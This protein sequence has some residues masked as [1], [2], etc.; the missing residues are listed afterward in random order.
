M[1]A[2]RRRFDQ[3]GSGRGVEFVS[4]LTISLRSSPACASFDFILYRGGNSINDGG[5]NPYLLEDL[6]V[7][8]HG[9]VWI[10]LLHGRNPRTGAEVV[11]ASLARGGFMV[12]D[13]REER[14]IQVRPPPAWH[15]ARAGTE[16]WAIG[17]APD[18]AIYV[19]TSYSRGGAD[20]LLRWNW[21][22]TTLEVVVDLP[23]PNFLSLD[24]APDGR[25]YLSEYSKNVLY[26]FTPATGA[27][28]DLGGFPGIE[29]HVSNVCCA[30]DGWVYVAVTDYK[31]TRCLAISPSDGKHFAIESVNSAPL[32]DGAGHVL[33]SRSQ[34]GGSVWSEL[35]GGRTVPIDGARVQLTKTEFCKGP[36][37]KT[38]NITPLAFADGGYIRRIDG[39]KFTH[40]DSKGAARSFTVERED[41]P[42][43]IFSVA[44]GGGKIWGGTFIPLTLFSYDPADGKT[45]CFG[46]PT[47]TDG[48]IY[49]MLFSSGKLFM[50]SYYGAFLTRYTPSRPWI[51]DHTPAANPAHL[52]RMKEDGLPLQRPHGKALAPD[53][54]VFFAAHGGYGCEESGICRIDPG[55]EEITR[56]IYPATSF[57]ALAW[58][59]APERLLVSERRTGEKGI[60]FTFISPRTGTV[61]WSEPVIQDDGEVVAWLYDGKDTVYGLHSWRATIFAFSVSAR[62]ITAEIRELGMGD[63]CW[64]SLIFG[65][66]ERIWGY[67]KTSIFAVS[68][69]LK[70]KEKILDY[71]DQAGGNFYRF[72]IC[73][74]P[75]GNLYFPNGIHLMRIKVHSNSG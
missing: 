22:G 2:T 44:A 74:G 21:E 48:E 3:A 43:R 58:L 26:R 13:P 34:W 45:E 42:L 29:G 39:T 72:G 25:V 53:G 19:A 69:D 10:K 60:R 50:G 16:V 24:V 32:K 38:E 54:T 55:T 40:V 18:G 64:E 73:Q 57:E 20:A 33:I 52:G 46:N 36:A 6:G 17:Q 65:P 56:W 12:I 71:P 31:K 41:L 47:E 23:F 7:Q 28:E 51:S 49:N 61:L 75:D 70:S 59:N 63:H 30:R 66:D 8:A 67:T 68:R 27:L 14:G 5:V 9:D 4:L 35:V 62:K 15:A 37:G 11:I 1:S